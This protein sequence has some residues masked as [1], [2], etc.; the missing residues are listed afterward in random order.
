MKRMLSAGC[1]LREEKGREGQGIIF[2]A[3][4]PSSFSAFP[5]NFL[6]PRCP[7]HPLRLA[8][9]ALRGDHLR[10]R[11]MRDR[12]ADDGSDVID[13]GVMDGWPADRGLM[14]C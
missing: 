10:A 11:A 8:S 12:W 4:P 1:R 7:L 13:S 9:G 14:Q 2:S 3:S 5:S 6:L